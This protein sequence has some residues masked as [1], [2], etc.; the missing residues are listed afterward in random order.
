MLNIDAILQLMWGILL[1]WG[2][3]SLCHSDILVLV[4]VFK[5]YHR[6]IVI[7]S[8]Y[9]ISSFQKMF[10]Y[11]K[12]YKIHQFFLMHFLKPHYMMRCIF[13]IV[14]FPSWFSSVPISN[15]VMVAITIYNST[16]NNS[17]FNKAISKV[18][19]TFVILKS[20]I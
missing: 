11:Y 5:N 3:R 6:V 12:I 13:I 15:F 7:L 10:S 17:L 1:K 9:L 2:I 4:V 19:A 16:Y 20:I 18:I 8:K 14:H